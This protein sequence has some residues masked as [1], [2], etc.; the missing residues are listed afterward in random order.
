MTTHNTMLMETAFGRESVFIL[1]NTES[2]KT[3]AKCINDHERRTYANNNIRNK[4]LNNEYGGIPEVHQIQIEEQVRT[5][6]EYI[7]RRD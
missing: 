2:N 1:R 3:E 6:K 7:N 5:L 4:Y